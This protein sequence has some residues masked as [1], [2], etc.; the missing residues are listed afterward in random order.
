VQTSLAFCVESS[1]GAM[2]RDCIYLDGTSRLRH[3][4]QGTLSTE[5]GAKPSYQGCVSSM[6]ARETQI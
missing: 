4:K 2:L 5:F 3:S 6:L 1:N